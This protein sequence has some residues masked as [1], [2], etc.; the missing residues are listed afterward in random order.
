MLQNMVP[1]VVTIGPPTIKRHQ[2]Y[3]DGKRHHLFSNIN[4]L[5]FR[6]S[7]VT[8]FKYFFINRNYNRALRTALVDSF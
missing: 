2:I 7:P 8:E 5:L 3:L 4:V 6:D 1:W